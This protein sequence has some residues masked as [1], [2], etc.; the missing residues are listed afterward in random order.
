MVNKLSTKAKILTVLRDRAGKP[1]SGSRLAQ[2][3]GVSRVAVWKG[4]QA[5][6]ES[7]YPIET[8]VPGY[9]M[10]T[11]KTF[12]FLY[13]WEFGENESQFRYYPNIGSTM[14]Q[15]RELAVQ[16]LEAGTVIVAEKQN[17]GRGRNGRTWASRQGGLFC[18]ILERPKMGLA[19]YCLPAM[20]W[21]IAIAK[22]LG[23][24]C[25]KPALLRWPN[26]VYIGNRKIAGV[27]TELAGEGDIVKW[28]AIGIGVNVNNKALEGST[29]GA[30]APVGKIV[31]CADITGHTLSRRDVLLK[32]INEAEQ[33]R[34]RSFSG[35]AYAQGNRL[36]AEEWNSIA[37]CIGARVAVIDSGWGDTI[38]AA[39]PQ[40]IKNRVLAKGIFAGVDPAGRCIIKSEHG[41]GALF[42]NPGPVSVSF[43]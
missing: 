38:K 5:L 7:G 39:A 16:G 42:F 29:P 8:K 2:D 17:A 24:I 20:F 21:Q 28:L 36:L 22:V 37:D 4:I 31:S 40:F 13:P 10:D 18:T 25:G 26:D 23:S 34:K 15:A 43:L 19:D 3:I 35:T 32:I 33:L 12:D 27:L 30:H 6:C 11:E 41:K 1:V 14:D 9:A